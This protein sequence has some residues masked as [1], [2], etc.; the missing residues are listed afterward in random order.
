DTSAVDVKAA[1]IRCNRGVLV[2]PIWQGKFS[3]FVPGQAAV[4]KLVITVPQVAK[5]SQAW[6]VSPGDVRGLKTERVDK[7]LR[8]TLPEFG[9]TSMVV[10]TSDTV[11]M[12][13]FQDQARSKR[14]LAAQW[15]H[16]MAVYEYEKVAKVH[17]E[18]E[19]MGVTLPD[20]NSLLEDARKRTAKSEELHTKTAFIF[21][22]E[23]D[24]ISGGHFRQIVDVPET[25]VV[26]VAVLIGRR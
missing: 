22:N 10:F 9:L 15:S 3:Q 26:V 18:L 1:V 25:F 16:D 12:G 17:I 7:G 2:I 24:G 6:E 5:T 20:G 8:I 21:L 13:R 11:L 23:L 19:K 14:Q 4:S